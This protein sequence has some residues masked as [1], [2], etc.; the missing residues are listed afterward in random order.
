M[1]ASARGL[2][3]LA[4]IMANKGHFRGKRLLSEETWIKM[5]SSPK[6]QMMLPYM[7]S[8]FTTGGVN[9]FE[10]FEDIPPIQNYMYEGR[11]GYFGW[12]GF[13]GSVF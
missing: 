13:G 10:H 2:S 1:T 5:H 8:N 12:L 11:E 6:K 9:C 4:V 7:M 3:K